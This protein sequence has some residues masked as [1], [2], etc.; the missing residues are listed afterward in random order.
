[1]IGLEYYQP[2]DEQIQNMGKIALAT[3][4]NKIIYK[5]IDTG[6]LA[7]HAGCDKQG[8]ISKTTLEQVKGTHLCPFCFKEIKSTTKQLKH[9]GYQ[10]VVKHMGDQ[11]YGYYVYYDF[12]LGKEMWCDVD[13]VLYASGDDCYHRYICFDLFANNVSLNAEKYPDWK[14]S[15]RSHWSCTY[16]R[17]RNSYESAMYDYDYRLEFFQ[18]YKTKKQYLEQEASFI[19]KSNQ[20]QLV[21]ENLFDHD[22]MK[23]IKVFDLKSADEIKRNRKYIC[24]E[25]SHIGE[26]MRDDITLNIYYLD[27]LRKNK[28]D[29]GKYYTYIKR[30]KDL[31]FKYDK[32]TDF[33]FR[34]EKIEAMHKQALEKLSN[35]KIAKRYEELPKYSES[36][37]S[38]SPF[39][40]AQEVRDC[41]KNLHCCI[42]G[43]VSNYANKVTDI[44]HCDLDGALKVALEIRQGELIQA[45]GD[46]NDVCP[47][48]LLEHIKSF[49]QQNNFSLGK[50][51]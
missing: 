45:R 22:E 16:Y 49:C 21:I 41:G 39:K 10:F 28:I 8:I 47:A 12:E 23:F 25:H 11:A 15:K 51:A 3:R 27:Y 43:F 36:N 5:E 34:Y 14:Y 19:Q 4:C 37:V 13:Q 46:H 9:C 7:Y 38:I 40:S 6:Y 35:E 44:Y 30:L 17:E 29:L 42:G 32:P 48:N 33:K 18:D 24:H 50:Y 31:G 2:T 1:M 20:K 26:F